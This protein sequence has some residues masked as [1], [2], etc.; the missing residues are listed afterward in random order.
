MFICEMGVVVNSHL[1]GRKQ[2]FINL[3][4]QTGNVPFFFLLQFQTYL[5]DQL[6][7]K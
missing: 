2:Y 5:P 4:I 1:E 6:Y 3:M 7:L